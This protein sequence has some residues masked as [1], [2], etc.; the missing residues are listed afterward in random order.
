MLIRMRRVWGRYCSRH[1][2]EEDYGKDENEEEEEEEELD[3]LAEA[4]GV[5]KEEELGKV[6][7]GSSLSLFTFKI[8]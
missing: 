2:W 8:S 6:G 7:N 4:A 3:L 5:G 1:G